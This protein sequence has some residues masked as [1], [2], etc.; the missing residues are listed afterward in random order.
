MLG[1]G[2][3]SMVEMARCSHATIIWWTAVRL[4][5]QL[6]MIEKAVL[7]DYHDCNCYYGT[8]ALAVSTVLKRR[9]ITYTTKV[10]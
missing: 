10:V 8:Y 9:H 3:I 2:H 7:V 6:V 1:S 4:S 5:I